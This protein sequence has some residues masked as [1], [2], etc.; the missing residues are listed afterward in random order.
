MKLKMNLKQFRQLKQNEIPEIR[1]K[2]LLE[3]NGK[4]AICGD[5]IDEKTG[6]SLD[7]QH[8][9]IADNI[10]SDGAG[11]IRGV[12]CRACNVIEGK[13]WNNMNR[14]KQPENIQDR[15][16][17]LK[18]LLQYY[19]KDNYALIHPSEKIKEK[20]VSKRNYNKL[21]K[22]YSGK[23]AFP[24]YPASGKLTKPLNVLFEKYNISPWN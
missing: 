2:I 22:L 17:F 15:I 8:K 20:S 19:K 4:C 24:K 9:R 3:Q 10:G 13:I 6:V 14:Y 21:R 5:I 23:A 11:L 16:I 18:N 1:E 12:L 7:H